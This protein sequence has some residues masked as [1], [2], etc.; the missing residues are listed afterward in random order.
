MLPDALAKAPPSMCAIMPERLAGAEPFTEVTEVVGS[1]PYCYKADERVVGSLVVYER[2]TEYVPRDGGV[3]DGTAGPKVAWFDRVEWHII[4]DQATAAA[5]LQDGEVDWWLTPDADLLTALRKRPKITVETLW[6]TGLI[7]TLRFN[8]L[9]P[10]FD[11]PAIRRAIVHAVSQ[12]DYMIGMA[13]TDPAMWRDRVG[14]FC[15]GS[16]MASNAGMEALTS[17]RDLGAVRRALEQ[18]GYGN[19]PVVVLTPTDVAPGRA[20]AEITA[21]TLRQVGMR[22]QAQA[23]DWAE[24]VRRRAIMEPVSQGGWSIFHTSWSGLDM[25]NPAAHVFLRANGTAAAPGWPD[26][27]KIEDLRDAW[28]AA[29]ELAA[30]R[31]V[32]RLLQLQAFS[33]VPYI[34]LGQYSAPTAY[35]SNLTGVL[36]GNPVFW[37]LRRT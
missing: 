18:A 25:V 34:P 31:A 8:H 28:F 3:A 32:A 12:T 14:Y 2:N 17:P 36:K 10:P 30:Q 6:P 16:A 33:D 1:G 27:T 4:P 5:A 20:L 21:D 19:E 35:R 15:P 22:V 37:N 9:H 11:N 13:G 7:A 29:P 24:L 23:M 26:S